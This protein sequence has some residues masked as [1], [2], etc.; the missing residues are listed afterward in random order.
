MVHGTAKSMGVSNNTQG[1]SCIQM[2]CWLRLD[3]EA[4]C[5]CNALRD[6]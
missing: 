1:T 3:P 2:Y 5:P 6:R 4:R